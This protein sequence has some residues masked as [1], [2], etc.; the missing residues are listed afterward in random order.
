[1]NVPV[2]RMPVPT[3]VKTH[4]VHMP[5]A[6][7]QDTPSMLMDALAVTSMSALWGLTDADRTAPTPSAVT[8]AA[9][10]LAIPS[11]LM[12]TH[13]MILMS[14]VQAP[15]IPASKAASISLGPTSVNA[16]LDLG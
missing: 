15:L 7:D 5:A 11:T 1:M 13:V 16:D 2:A 9:V 10:I 4:R 14:V 12:G 6:V 3:S 8:P